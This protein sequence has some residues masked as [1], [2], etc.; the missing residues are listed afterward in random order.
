MIWLE[1]S[2][3]IPQTEFFQISTVVF[4]IVSLTVIIITKMKK[5][6]INGSHLIKS[7]FI[8]IDQFNRCKK[9]FYGTLINPGSKYL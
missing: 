3:I 5:P 7:N 2:L 6:K 8:I 9:S 4:F 1:L